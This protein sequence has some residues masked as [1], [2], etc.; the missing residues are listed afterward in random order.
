MASAPST[1]LR[2]PGPAWEIAHLFPDQGHISEGEY[3]R[4][5]DHT[6]RL[7]EYVNG[8]IEVLPMP[9][10][11]H[12]RILLF[13]VMLLNDFVTPRKLGEVLM[14]AMRVKINDD[15]YREPDLLFMLERNSHKKNNRYWN[16]AD[17]VMEVVSKDDPNRDL[18]DKRK[19]YARAGV[20]EYW[21]VNPQTKTVTVLRLKKDRYVTHSQAT[22]TGPVRSALLDGFTADAAAIF[23]AGKRA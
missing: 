14:A 11:E 6:R 18:V 10:M 12:Q 7:A 2:K 17:L 15:E 9:T 23:A 3:L 20:S 4:L 21:I 1:L 16:G 5:T 8:R 19:Q 22:G 13:L